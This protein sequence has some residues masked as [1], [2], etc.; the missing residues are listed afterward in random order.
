[1]LFLVSP[2]QLSTSAEVQGLS[3]D[4]LEELRLLRR[5]QKRKSVS[6]DGALEGM[7]PT[8]IQVRTFLITKLKQIHHVSSICHP[9]Q[10]FS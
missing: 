4:K 7:D 8:F 6:T 3:H 5:T 9:Q 10:P 1:M 2:L